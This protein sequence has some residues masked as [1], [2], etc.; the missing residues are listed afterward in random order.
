MTF[1]STSKPTYSYH[2]SGEETHRLATAGGG[3]HIAIAH[4]EEGDGDEPQRCVHVACRCLGLPAGRRK[5]GL[6]L[7]MAKCVNGP[8]PVLHIHYP[9]CIMLYKYLLIILFF[10]VLAVCLF[11]CKY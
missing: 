2:D 7:V 8:G 4:C 5:H 11:I 1:F 3:C 6:R 9:E 10:V